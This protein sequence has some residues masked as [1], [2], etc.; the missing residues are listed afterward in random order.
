MDTPTA[1]AWGKSVNDW[2]CGNTGTQ[3][4]RTAQLS[5]DW[6]GLEACK[7]KQCPTEWGVRFHINSQ[8]CRCRSSHGGELEVGLG[9]VV[10]VNISNRRHCIELKSWRIQVS[11]CQWALWLPVASVLTHTFSI[12]CPN[13]LVNDLFPNPM[14]VMILCNYPVLWVSNY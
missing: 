11:V 12:L 3:W 13:K 6:L 9:R 14:I 10:P 4:H 8:L 5:V 7:K 2:R 1:W